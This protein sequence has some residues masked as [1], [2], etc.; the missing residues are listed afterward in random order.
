MSTMQR[1]PTISFSGDHLV[2]V[3][4]YNPSHAIWYILHHLTGLPETWLNSTD[5]AAVAATLINEDRGICILFDQ[6]QNAQAYIEN[7]NTHVDG[8]LRYGS[9]GNSIRS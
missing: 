9:D 4:D 1:T 8:I 7:L 5:F 2:R 3:T 6:Q